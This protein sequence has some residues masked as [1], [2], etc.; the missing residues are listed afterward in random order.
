MLIKFDAK[1][2]KLTRNRRN[3]LT[4]LIFM[5]K[6]IN[7]QIVISKKV[8]NNVLDG[9]YEKSKRFMKS[10]IKELQAKDQWMKKIYIRKF[11]SSRRLRKQ[12]QKWIIN[13][14][15][16]VKYNKCLYIFDDAIV[17]EELIKKYYDDS[18]SEHF[19]I[20]K[21]L[22]LIQ[23]KYFWLICAKQMKTYVQRCNSCQRIKVSHYKFYKE[24]SSLSVPEVSWKKLNVN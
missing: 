11:T 21:T 17:K 22:S 20:Q 13:D 9:S 5:F 15:D 1:L 7:I 8:I 14:E 16:L 19:K 2:A 10:L 4:E 24:L 23:R 18:L 6:L 12:F 3:I